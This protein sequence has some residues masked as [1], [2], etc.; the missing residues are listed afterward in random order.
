M[1]IDELTLGQIKEIQSL[2]CGKTPAPSQDFPFKVGE[3]VF[4]RTVTHHQAGRIVSIGRDWVLLDEA[5]WIADDGRFHEALA[6]GV[7]KEVEPVPG[8]CMVGRGAIVDMFPWP[9]P[10]PRTVK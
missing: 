9:H 4:I 2:A 8:L 1:N 10:L 6:K 7:F 3:S 5:A